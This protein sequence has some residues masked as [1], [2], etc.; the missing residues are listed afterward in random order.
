MAIKKLYIAI[1]CANDQ[2]EQAAQ[3]VLKQ[4]SNMRIFDAK[5]LITYYPILKSR[6]GTIRE[7]FNLITTGGIK[8]LLSMRGMGLIKSLTS[9]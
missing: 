3:E 8:S 1:E 6:E 2:E 5:K 9:K 7:L 4:L